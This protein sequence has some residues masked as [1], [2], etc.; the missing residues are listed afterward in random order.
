MSPIV[1]WASLALTLAVGIAIGIALVRFTAVGSITPERASRAM[2]LH[3]ELRRALDR[4]ELVLHYQPKIELGTGRVS[5]LEALVR[6]QHPERGLLTPD[7]FL[8]VAE[9]RSEL[10]GSLTG[11]VLRLALA[12]YKAWTAAGRDWTVVSTSQ[13]RTLSPRTSRSPWA[14]SCRRRASHPTGLRSR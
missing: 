10:L 11:W 3:D 4:D 2:V 13:P 5:C 6:W 8:Y 1:F 14:R 9:Q 7:E 12:D